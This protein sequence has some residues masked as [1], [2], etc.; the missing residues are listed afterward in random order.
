LKPN[1]QK[2]AIFIR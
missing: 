2:L 1:K